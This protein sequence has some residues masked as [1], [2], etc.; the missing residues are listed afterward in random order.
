MK[1]NLI[2]I[3]IL[4]FSLPSFAQE[5]KIS[6]SLEEAIKMALENSYNT[7]ASKNN[8]L[9]AQETVWE[10]TATGLPQID[11]KVDYQNFIKQPV[12]LLPAAAFDNTASVVQ[13]VED[14][15]G[16]PSNR[17]PELPQGF[18]P[19]VFGTQQNINASVTVKQ[20]LFDGSYLVG[21]Q[22]SR[23][24]L[25]ISEQANEKTEI[26]T[27]EAVVNAYG[28]VLVTEKSIAILE[29]NLKILEKNLNDAKMIYENGFNEQEDVEQLEITFGTLKNQLY[30]LQRMRGIAYQMLNLSIGV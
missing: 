18:I 21:L 25:K 27:R 23:A 17:D 7:K 16:I 14:Y 8:V 30:N 13:T 10:T 1:K 26:L 2:L 5:T 3:L 6:L 4:F 20:L 24:F 19:V 12:S 28:N 9:S 22:A 15:F 29:G 11:A